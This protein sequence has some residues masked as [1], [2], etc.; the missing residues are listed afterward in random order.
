MMT[1]HD[2]PGGLMDVVKARAT[3]PGPGFY[4]PEVFQ[5]PRRDGDDA[6][7]SEPGE[8][9]WAPKGYTF[10]WRGA[11]GDTLR[12]PVG[13]TSPGP[14]EY[15][16][17]DAERVGE[18]PWRPAGFTIGLSRSASARSA[19][20]G[21][22]GPGPGE[23]YVPEDTSRGSAGRR[24]PKRGARIQT[25]RP[26]ERAA[27][28]EKR[29]D[30][31]GPAEYAPG[32]GLRK[33]VQRRA[34]AHAVGQ[35]QKPSKSK[36]APAPG[37]GDYDVEYRPIGAGAPGATVG[38]RFATRDD[39]AAYPAPGEYHRDDARSAKKTSVNIAKGATRDAP[40]GVFDAARR[41]ASTP[42]PGEFDAAFDAARR[43]NAAAVDIARGTGR[44]APGGALDVARRGADNPGPGEHW[45]DDDSTSSSRKK[46]ARGFSF[47]RTGHGSVGGAHDAA[48]R[49]ADEPGP[50]EFWPD[51]D[52]RAA[53]ARRKK[54]GAGY[55]IPRTGHGAVGGALDAAR[56]A[57]NEPGPGDFG[58]RTRPGDRS[59]GRKRPG[60]RGIS[61]R[62]PVGTPRGGRPTSALAIRPV[63][64]RTGPTRRTRAR[65]RT[66][67]ACRSGNRPDRNRRRHRLAG[68][69]RAS[70]RFWRSARAAP[71]RCLARRDDSRRGVR[72]GTGTIA[73]HRETTSRKCIPRRWRGYSATRCVSRAR[74]GRRPRRGRF[75][76]RTRT[77]IPV[78][79]ITTRQKIQT[80]GRIKARRWRRG[81]RGN[82]RPRERRGERTRA[83]QVRVSEQRRRE[84]GVD[85]RASR[86]P[87]ERFRRDP[88]D[89]EIVQN[90]GDEKA[91]GD[92]E[93]L[94]ERGVERTIGDP[95]IFV[96]RNAS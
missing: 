78:P 56:R 22:P 55:T 16:P 14:G 60:I 5:F 66:R 82:A 4:T 31:P 94:V 75:G 24:G 48:R 18:A 13:E 46:N 81:R 43:R 96:R 17:D 69:G 93:Y 29:G 83:E 70:T 32:A 88:R 9:L 92:D 27:A 37:P 71:G 59:D 47:A 38:V 63:R 49:A 72:R 68:P 30:A 35:K 51:E 39:A 57:A 58:P 21:D 42:G 44:E 62:R 40:G 54:S 52:V 15:Y 79:G 87:R 10:G 20:S 91:V 23:Y 2:A 95:S 73:P 85:R 67:E 80:S 89:D 6:T 84:S 50:G 65:T 41:A 3:I 34:P 77:G 76:G 25:R 11:F 36:T 7:G 1:N 74:F 12:D 45:P 64:A 53:A 33:H 26:W 8:F 19:T 90:D 86:A 28:R 61:V